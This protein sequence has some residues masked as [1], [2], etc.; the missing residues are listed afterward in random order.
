MIHESSFFFR[1]EKKCYHMSHKNDN[2]L[3]FEKDS[4]QIK[5]FPSS[6]EDFRNLG[7]ES[8]HLHFTF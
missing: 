3:I 1:D 8:L 4:P 2:Y 7:E 6:V 5:V